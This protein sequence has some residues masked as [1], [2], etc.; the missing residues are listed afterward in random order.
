[1]QA[2]SWGRIVN[3]ASSAG[4]EGYPYVT[5][6]CAAKHGVVGL[7]RALARELARGGVTVNAVC[8]GYTDTDML[9]EAVQAIIKRTGQA[10]ETV[11]AH[12]AA[13]NPDGRLL[14]PE[15]VAQEVVHF[16]LPDASQFNGE[17]ASFN[18]G[19]AP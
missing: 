16:C 9:H 4:L 14:S 17:V 1:M 8:P 13:Q 15:E 2:A 10:G 19:A 11:R 18:N 6:Y 7:T 5:A 12:L 3:V